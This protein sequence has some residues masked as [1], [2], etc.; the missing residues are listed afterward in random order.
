MIISL[1]AGKAFDKIQLLYMLN[2]METSGIQVS[3]LNT[4]KAIHNKPIANIKLNG[5]GFK[6]IPLKLERRHGC[7]LS[8]Y[9][10][11]T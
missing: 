6:S 4:V 9:L 7:P 11:L 1:D 3:H 5:E 10:S 2:A 8:P